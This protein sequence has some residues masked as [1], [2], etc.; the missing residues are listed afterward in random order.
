MET[1]YL[2]SLFRSNWLNLLVVFLTVM[3][4]C[5]ISATSVWSLSLKRRRES[6]RKNKKYFSDPV[7]QNHWI[8]DVPKHRVYFLF[9]NT[10]RSLPR[11][12]VGSL[13]VDHRVEWH[14]ESHLSLL[15]LLSLVQQPSDCSE[16]RPI[17]KQKQKV[18]IW[19]EDRR[20]HLE[21]T[22]HFDQS[23][24]SS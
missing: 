21:N 9:R 2:V 10:K 19:S 11:D 15:F 16:L 14:S 17:H 24:K 5:E 8:E 13:N 4:I 22:F 3:Y 18:A 7:K 1:L 6:D 12:N 23:S 20:E